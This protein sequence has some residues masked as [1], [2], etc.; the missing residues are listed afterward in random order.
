MKNIFLLFL[1][2]LNSLAYRLPIFPDIIRSHGVSFKTRTY[3]H[4]EKF[5]KKL[6]L[7]HIGVSFVEGNKCARF[8]FRS[9]GEEEISFMT[10]SSNPLKAAS[11]QILNKSLKLNN[12]DIY[13]FEFLR[14]RLNDNTME[15]IDIYWG[16]SNKTLKEIIE[17][18]KGLNKNYFVGINDCRH[19]SRELTKWALD[20]PSPVWK[21]NKLFIKY[22]NLNS[23]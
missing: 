16:L 3:L 17:F 6:N 8:D 23:N 21:L 2:F 15:T 22:K 13:P 7:L 19:Y 18:E 20:K 4:I 10:Y 9:I 11:L 5:S 14:Y 12:E 1:I